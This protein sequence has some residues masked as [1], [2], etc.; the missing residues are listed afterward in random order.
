MTRDFGDKIIIYENILLGEDP[1]ISPFVVLGKKP[2]G[3]NCD[4]LKLVIGKNATIRSFTT[5]YLGS[6]IGDFFSTGQNVS[7]REDNAIGNNVSIGTCSVVEFGNIIGDGTRIHS[8]CFLEMVT[9]GKN[10]FVG[11]NV[12]FTDDP[13]PMKCPDYKKC[14]GG[15]VIEDLVKIGA[16]STILP[17][18]RIG[19]N[20]L[21]GAGS[22][23]VK[24]VPPDEVHAGNPA[25]FI[26][27]ISD[28]K[29]EKGFFEKPYIWEP[30]I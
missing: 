2:L 19:R 6:I 8:C 10:V 29:C 27:K 1:D 13:H 3:G 30:Y 12:V 4:E 17:G 23:V 20:S 15:A 9:I 16:N 24:D 14:K 5:I 22:V 21:I 26:K 28:L 25:K 11:P 18:I 7:I